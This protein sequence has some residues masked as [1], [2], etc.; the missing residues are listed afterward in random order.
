MSLIVKT[1]H[2]FKVGFLTSFLRNQLA[3]VL[4]CISLCSPASPYEQEVKQLSAKIAE[5]TEKSGRKTIA[6]VDFT[7][8]EGNVTELGRFLA[9]EL[10]LA[11]ASDAKGFEVIDRTNLK[12]ILQEHKLASTGIIDPQTAR[13]LGEI[14]G[15]QA[16]VTGTITPFGDSV[17]L[18]VK[19]LDTGTAKVLGGFAGEIPRTKAIDE[20]LSKGVG[21]Q[22]PSG[23]A[24]SVK[25]TSGGSSSEADHSPAKSRVI[26][27]RVGDVS[28][29]IRECRK[30]LE[31][32]ICSGSV[33]NLGND[34]FQLRLNPYASYA[35]DNLGNQTRT[36]TIVFGAVGEAQRLDPEIPINFEFRGSPLAPDASSISLVLQCDGNLASGQ[37][38]FGGEGSRAIAIKRIPLITK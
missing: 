9:E 22:A 38:L 33:S 29:A 31:T 32:L 7:D 26:T 20:L 5:S 13:K 23:D 1:G 27:A 6:V 18:S 28:I 36:N 10:S 37:G 25:L 35:V 4:V 12:T 19:L 15:V 3:A 17:R 14:A 16:L 21:A 8:L 11:L 24:N 2:R 34:R 30:P